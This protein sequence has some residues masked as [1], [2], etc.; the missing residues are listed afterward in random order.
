MNLLEYLRG[1]PKPK[2]RKID[3]S[4]HRDL[5]PGWLWPYLTR[6]DEVT[7]GR[8]QYWLYVAQYTAEHDCLPPEPIPQIE[9]EEPYQGTPRGE[10]MKMLEHCMEAIAPSWQGWS[11]WD[12]FEYFLQ[13]LLYGMDPTGRHAPPRRDFDG[14]SDR[15]YQVFN[16]DLMLLWPSDYWGAM[17]AES[18]IGR[19]VGFYP[20]PHTVCDAMAKM[21]IDP[22]DHRLESACDPAL[23][24]GRLMLFASN[25]CL[26]LSGQDINPLCA[27]AAEVNAWMYAPWMAM[28][29]RWVE[30]KIMERH[31][32]SE[33]EPLAIGRRMNLQVDRGQEVL[34]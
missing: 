32:H 24:T 10:V 4:V 5:K 29:L 33:L 19:H 7:W 12:V 31:Q 26:S 30:A 13:W 28:P 22:G 25:Y 16:L 23:G 15:L 1:R 2:E 27:L 18:R 14:A 8:W 3:P 21:A 17:F 9:L 6:G 20:T 11:S 34:L